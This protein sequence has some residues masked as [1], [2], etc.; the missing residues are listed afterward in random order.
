MSHQNPHDRLH[1]VADVRIEVKLA[2][3][4]PTTV[5]RIG[6]TSAVQPAL[7][8]R[9]IPWSITVMIVLIAAIAIWS[10]TRPT[11]EPITRLALTLTEQLGSTRAGLDENVVALSPDGKRLVYVTVQGLYLRPMDSLQASPIP[12]T[13]EALSAFFSPDGQWVGFFTDGELKKVSISGGAPLTL[14]DAAGVRGAS[15]GTDNTIVFG[16]TG[17]GLSQVSAAGGTPRQLTTLDSKTGETDQI[18]P[19]ILPG[20]KAVLFT[21]RDGGNL[22]NWQIVVQS[23]ETGERQVLVQGTY[24]R[25]VVTG[26]L[27]YAQAGTPGT[28]LAVPFDVERL[29]VTGIP[30]PIV[31]GVQQS[32]ASGLAQFSFS[33]LGT[34]VYVPGGTGTG[35]SRLVWVDRQGTAEPLAAPPHLYRGP[36]LSPDGGR[37]AVTITEPKADIWVYEI[38]RQTLTRLTFEGS[39]NQ[40]PQW[41]PDGKRVTWRSIREGVPGNLFWK[42]ADGTGAAERLTTSEF[43]QNPG[44]WSP[45]GQFLAFHQRPSTGSSPTERD[46]WILPLEGERKPQSILQ[47]QFNELGPVFSPDGRWLAYISDESGRNEIYIRPFPKVEEGKWQISTAGG[48][49]PRWARNGRELFYRNE[50]GDQMIVV[51][52]TGEPTFRAGTPRVLFEGIYQRSAGGAA[53]YD[54]RPDAQRFLMVQA[55]EQGAGA[56]QINVILNWFEELKRLV[57]TH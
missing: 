25:Y 5:P 33:D 19:Q 46:I 8:K 6:V 26:H 47:T 39:E 48:V 51:E 14:C 45:D 9:A 24:A 11:P 56:G 12:G 2:L 16:Q 31:E 18:H 23:P 27:V 20:G 29:E 53:F 10:L 13:E 38:A 1:E 40:Q 35:L 15:W 28:L 44:S 17:A 50:I 3:E 57:P 36:S 41:T 4:E 52:I 21:S 54:V 34:F 49:E 43:R 55:G 32:A 37:V 30:V 7:W 22:D 42:L